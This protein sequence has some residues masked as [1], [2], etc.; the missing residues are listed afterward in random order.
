MD[1]VE[2]TPHGAGKVAEGPVDEAVTWDTPRLR[3][4]LARLREDMLRAADELR[5]EEAAALRD[6]VKQLEALELSR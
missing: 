3:G 4:E 5:F 6:R 2:P 1:Y